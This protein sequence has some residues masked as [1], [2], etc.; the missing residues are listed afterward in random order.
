MNGSPSAASEKNHPADSPDESPDA[1]RSHS[2]AW[3]TFCENSSLILVVLALTFAPLAFGAVRVWS[4]GLVHL[5]VLAAFCMWILRLATSARAHL[6]YSPMVLPLLA[7]AWYAAMR[8][9]TTPVEYVAR[10]EFLGIITCLLAFF[11]LTHNAHHRWQ[12]NFLTVLWIC[13]A[14]GIAVYGLVQ[15]MRNAHWVWWYPQHPGYYGRASGTYLCPNHF[16]GYL[17]MILA[18]AAAQFLFSRR[19]WHWKILLL[20]A[21]FVMIAGIVFS[22]SR[23]GW[24]SSFTAAIVLLAFLAKY[25]A[26]RFRF[27]AL[28]FVFLVGAIIFAAAG[29]GSVRERIE[30]TVKGGEPTRLAMWRAAWRIGLENP[31]FGAGAG[32]Y[33]VLYPA[34]RTMQARPAYTHN[35]YANAFADYGIVGIAL[36][37]WLI[38][39]FFYSVGQ[40]IR[41]RATK[42]AAGGPSNRFAFAIGAV[43]AVSALLVH[44]I[45]DFN[46]HILANSLTLSCIAAVALNCKVHPRHDIHLSGKRRWTQQFTVRLRG[47]Q[48]WLA[49]GCLT[50]LLV[51]L[52]VLA[53]RNYASHLYY[54]AA[55]RHSRALNRA[56]AERFYARAWKLDSQNFH[57]AHDLGNFYANRALWNAARRAEFSQQAFQWFDHALRANP[58]HADTLIARA[59]LH[60][61]LGQREEAHDILQRAL[62]IDP[63]NAN[64]LSQLG[65][66]YLRWG[67]REK[68]AEAVKKAN[69]LKYQDPVIRLQ[70]R[71]LQS[72]QT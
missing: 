8:Y 34:H 55:E 20:A 58:W 68:A 35:D 30:I 36:I 17:E 7:I 26:F 59:K 29:L 23:G 27:A 51:W 62:V 65:Q 24:L 64:Y 32:M 11:V 46:M 47:L 33:D 38:G 37:A 19:D 3:H 66:H 25:K 5:L 40:N 48:K 72:P 56:Q 63:N 70:L 4:Q 41:Q 14:S 50:A 54:R 1:R 67:D 10:Q 44:S 52:T 69:S 39:A 60:D 42:T 13:L 57:L 15:W 53:A 61:L 49:V 43:V 71:H 9:L 28:G 2:S 45:F 6:S 31:T 16:S 12:I 22:Y 18:I 21:C